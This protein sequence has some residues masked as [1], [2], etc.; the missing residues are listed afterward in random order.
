MNGNGAT[1]LT[2]PDSPSTPQNVPAQTTGTQITFTWSAGA[3]NGGS[4]VLDY[5]IMYDE[6]R[7]DSVYTTLDTQE[8]GPSYTATLLTAGTTYSFKVYARNAQGYSLGSSPSSI[9]A[10]QIPDT[11]SAPTTTIQGNFV[12]IAWTAPSAQGSPITSY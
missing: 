7:G 4:S 10:A 3:S 9:L 1:I 2:I 8:A 6:G 11:P 5:K 12:K